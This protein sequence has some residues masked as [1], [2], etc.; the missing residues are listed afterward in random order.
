MLF[1]CF[2]CLN[3]EACRP[4]ER[5]HAAGQER[6]QP[7]LQHRTTEKKNNKKIGELVKIQVHDLISYGWPNI[8]S[9]EDTICSSSFASRRHVS[10]VRHSSTASSSSPSRTA[11]LSS[12]L[13]SRK[14]DLITEAERAVC[15]AETDE[16]RRDPASPDLPDQHDGC[17]SD[18]IHE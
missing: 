1:D 8:R 2:E 15:S 14:L 11:S 13:F 17:C 4:R 10:T 7:A 3:A 16:S 9:P 5:I 12:S 6:S 18:L